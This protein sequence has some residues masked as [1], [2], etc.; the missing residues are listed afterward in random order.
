[1]SSYRVPQPARFVCVALAFAAILHL[2]AILGNASAQPPLKKES[3]PLAT[4]HD[5]KAA[6][7]FEEVARAYRSLASYSDQGEFALAMT[8]AGKQQKQAMPIKLTFVRPNKLELDAG[9]VHVVSDGTEL[10]TAVV[11]LKRYAT[12][13]APSKVGIHTF[14]EGPLGAVLFG[15]PAAMP[16]FV[17]L[18]LLTAPDPV[19]SIGQLS[20]SFQRVPAKTASS[21]TDSPK[22]ESPDLLIDL[23][24]GPD[25]ILRVNPATKLL[26]G[27]ELKIDP[28]Q[29]AK[30]A[31]APGAMTIEHLG[32]T[33][34]NVSTQVVGDRTFAFKPPD[35]FTKVDSLAAQGVQADKAGFSDK[36]GK[37]APDFTLT[38]LDGPEKT[39][40][41]TKAELAGKVVLIDF[42]ATWCGPCLM[43]LPEIQKLALDFADSKKDVLIV[44]VSQ[45][46]HPAEI[47]EVRRLVE[48]T[49]SDKGIN[50]A[51]IPVARV[52]LDPSH[53]VG[54]AFEVEGYP[55]LVI[56][57][58]KGNLQSAHVGFDPGAAEP[59]HKS[60]AKEIDAILSGKSRVAPRAVP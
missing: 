47:S 43:E 54:N 4:A 23:P 26:A 45:D 59:F 11:P 37:P 35:G 2:G 36:L 6:A 16:M 34:G 39:K 52:A 24:D 40:T 30:S 31:P 50:L 15:G 28:D 29:V 58:S 33:A 57:D 27:I 1:M 60:L 5:P 25:L 48:K 19:A 12:T 55:T 49:L 38:V 21:A 41:L 17:V 20:G 8:I 22:P 3:K 56:I 10:T 14:R 9:L 32:W 7:L 51:R 44:A 42:W 53:S 18:S 13:A 46:D